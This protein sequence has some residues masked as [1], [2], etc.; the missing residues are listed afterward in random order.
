[1]PTLT[2]PLALRRVKRWRK[3]ITTSWQRQVGAVIA[4]GHLLIRAHDD[5]ISI[6]GA[7]AS[8]VRNDL[9]F[10]HATAQKLM[11]IARH[12]VLADYSHGNRLPASWT[13]LYQLALIDPS[14]LNQLITSRQVNARTER[15]D[16]ERM[17]RIPLPGADPTPGTDLTVVV[18]DSRQVVTA[19]AAYRLATTRFF[20][21]IYERI[22]AGLMSE[23]E[24]QM[25]LTALDEL[26]DMMRE[27]GRDV[28]RR[29][30]IEPMRTVN[31]PM[32]ENDE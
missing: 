14:I 31:P 16:V 17:R 15:E 6:H 29:L 11:A 19:I 8:M 5:L 9:P 4:T 24:L 25:V 22:A 18:V 12:P 3:A 28:E 21:R 26:S 20:D 10:G 7:W 2:D 1:M 32:W 13:T 27:F 30:H 23:E